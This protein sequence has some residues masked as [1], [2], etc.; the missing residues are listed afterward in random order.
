MFPP[1]ARFALAYAAGIWIGLSLGVPPAVWALVGL[2]GIAVGPRLGWRSLLGITVAVGLAVGGAQA[3][4]ESES[5]AASWPVGRHT[6][7]LR[8]HDAPGE[9]GVTTAT[10]VY[11]PEGCDGDIRVRVDSTVSLASGA[12]VIAV[13]VVRS[14]GWLRVTHLRRL[15]WP[16]AWRFRVRDV[17]GARIARLY[18]ARA[19]LVEAVVL[20][21]RTDLDPRLRDRFAAGGVAHLLA[22]SGLHVGI[23]AAWIRVIAGRV[24]GV[25][26]AWPVSAV[27]TWAYVSLLGFPAPATRAATFVALAA[28]G[29]IRERRP[30]V[31]ALLAVAV[32]LVLT[33][34]PSAVRS[35]GA[36]LSVSAVAGTSVAITVMTRGKKATPLVRLVAASAGATLATAPITAYVFGSVAP[37]GVLSNLVAV[38][39]AG[40]AVPAVFAS[41]F[42]G[43]FMAAGAGLALTL[44]EAVASFAS[45]VPW[46]HLEGVP[47]RGFAAPWAAAVALALWASW[48]RPTRA[49]AA[50]RLAW[51]LAAGSWALVAIPSARASDADDRLTIYVLSVGQGD[52]I[53]IRTPRGRWILV[54][55][56]PRFGRVDAGRQILLPFFKRHHVARL[57][58][59]IISHGDADHL[60]G[61]PAV[62]AATEP[63]L[64]VEPG[65]PLASD[66]YREY[67]GAVEAHAGRWQVGRAG[68][69]LVVDS[70]VLALLHPSAVWMAR[71][72]L[73]NENSLIIHLRYRAFDAL[74]TGDAGASAE[75]ALVPRLR[76][77]EVL[78]VGHHGSA[79]STTDALLDAVRPAVAVISVGRNR[80]GHPTPEVLD[81]LGRRGVPVYRTDRGGTV[82]IRTD[83]RYFEIIQGPSLTKFR[84]VRCVFQTWLRSKHSSWSRSACTPR[85]LGNSRTF[86]TTSP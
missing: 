73:A 61:M 35:A 40:L 84:S 1:V 54:D 74:L 36:W 25:R 72:A 41:L 52:A 9:R 60:G 71:T 8:V 3:R 55:A 12:T 2:T 17:I 34:D 64:V 70:V 26:A 19:P 18:G 27:L 50:N 38:P 30:P 53:A 69:T 51:G 42:L 15:R 86:S 16:R 58:V 31:A 56:G 65:Q 82:T 46:G 11:A 48:R 21:R 39:L 59:A 43:A 47:G 29:R 85:Q 7:V 66:L 45:A 20:G 14:P 4:V 83:G 57:D 33:I 75:G 49:V 67:L 23:I 63:A 68:D 22:I 37:I 44:L 62:L 78:K 76:Q 28:L 5:C 77:M 24:V 81:R 80:F 32:L 79:G 6:A 10:V 13:G